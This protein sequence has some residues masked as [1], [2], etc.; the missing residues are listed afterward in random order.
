MKGN[1]QYRKV[2][3]SDNI[4]RIL[5]GDLSQA[6]LAKLTGLSQS[7]I[8]FYELGRFPKPDV[9]SKIAAA[10]GKKITWVIEDAND[11]E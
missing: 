3:T 7:S 6:E 5:R 2:I 1:C 9:L 10:V 11:P 8:A 4:V